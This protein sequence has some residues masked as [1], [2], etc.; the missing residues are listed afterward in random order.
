MKTR[1]N[2]ELEDYHNHNKFNIGLENKNINQQNIINNKF[3]F[4]DG[5][6][7]CS[8]LYKENNNVYIS[9]PDFETSQNPICSSNS[10]TNIIIKNRIPLN[11][12]I[13]GAVY[14]YKTLLDKNECKTSMLY[15]EDKVLVHRKH[16]KYL[17]DV[18]Y[19][20]SIVNHVNYELSY[21]Y[22]KNI[23]YD[24]LIKD[25]FKNKLRYYY[26][27]KKEDEKFNRL[28]TTIETRIYDETNK[29]ILNI[30]NTRKKQFILQNL[31][32]ITYENSNTNSLM[33]LL[34]TI[35]KKNSNTIL[36]CKNNVYS[37]HLARVEKILL[38]ITNIISKLTKF[39]KYREQAVDKYKTIFDKLYKLPDFS[40]IFLNPSDDSTFLQFKEV[41]QNIIEFRG[42][43]SEPSEDT[44]YGLKTLIFNILDDISVNIKELNNNIIALKSRIGNTVQENNGLIGKFLNTVEEYI[45]LEID[46]VKVNEEKPK[47]THLEILMSYKNKICTVMKSNVL[48]KYQSVVQ[49][50]SDYKISEIPD[51]FSL[52]DTLEDFKIN[53]D[54]IV[55]IYKN[56]DIFYTNLDTEYEDLP[57]YK[58]LY[59]IFFNKRN[60]Y[61]EYLQQPHKEFKDFI[62]PFITPEGEKKQLN[63]N[64]IFKV[65]PANDEQIQF[66]EKHKIKDLENIKESEKNQN[67][68]NIE[69]YCI[70]YSLDILNN[71]QLNYLTVK[72]KIIFSKNVLSN[73]CRTNILIEE[74]KKNIENY[75]KTI[76]FDMNSYKEQKKAKN[77]ENLPLNYRKGI[78]DFIYMNKMLFSITNKYIT[79]LTY[80]ISNNNYN[81]A[82]TSFNIFINS[83][84]GDE[85][86]L[87][88]DMDIINV[89]F[90]MKNCFFIK[91]KDY[92][93]VDDFIVIVYSLCISALA[94]NPQETLDA[95]FYT[96]DTN[97]DVKNLFDNVFHNKL[98]IYK[99]KNINIQEGSEAIEQNNLK[100]ISSIEEIVLS[101]HSLNKNNIQ[102]TQQKLN[103]LRSQLISELKKERFINIRKKLL[104]IQKF[105]GHTVT[106][107]INTIKLTTN[108][109]Q[110]SVI[111]KYFKNVE[112][113][114]I[115]NFNNNINNI[116]NLDN[117]YSIKNNTESNLY[118]IDLSKDLKYQCG[119]CDN[120]NRNPLLKLRAPNC[121]PNLP[122]NLDTYVDS[123]IQR[124]IGFNKD[125]Y[126]IMSFISEPNKELIYKNNSSIKYGRKGRMDSY[127]W[128]VNKGYK[129][130]TILDKTDTNEDETV[131]IKACLNNDEEN[132]PEK[133]SIV[134]ENLDKLAKN[135]N[136]FYLNNFYI[137][138]ILLEDLKNEEWVKFP[139]SHQ[140]YIQKPTKSNYYHVYFIENDIKYYMYLYIKKEK[141][142]YDIVFRENTSR[143]KEPFILNNAKWRFIRTEDYIDNIFDNVKIL[144][145]IRSKI[146]FNKSL[147]INNPNRPPP[148]KIRGLLAKNNTC[149]NYSTLLNDFFNNDEDLINNT[150]FKFEGY[151][152]NYKITSYVKSPNSIFNNIDGCL[153]LNY[154]TELKKL[155]QQQLKDG[156]IESQDDYDTKIATSKINTKI[157]LDPRTINA[158][159]EKKLV[160]YKIQNPDTQKYLYLDTT[161]NKVI[162]SDLYDD[163][164]KN[165]N[166]KISD[167][168]VLPDNFLWIVQNSKYNDIQINEAIKE[169]QAVYNNMINQSIININ[170]NITNKI[171]KQ[172]LK[173]SEN[174]KN[175]IENNEKFKNKHDKILNYVREMTKSD[176]IGKS[177]EEKEKIEK[178]FLKNKLL[179]MKGGEV[180]TMNPD[181]IENINTLVKQLKFIKYNDYKLLLN[182]LNIIKQNSKITLPSNF[183]FDNI[184]NRMRLKYMDSISNTNMTMYIY[185]TQMNKGSSK[186]ECNIKDILNFRSLEF[187][188]K[189]NDTENGDYNVFN[190][191]N[192][193]VEVD[194][195]TYD[196]NNTII[197]NITF[198]NRNNLI[199][200]KKGKNNILIKFNSVGNKDL[201]ISQI[202]INLPGVAE[203][204]I[205]NTKSDVL[206]YYNSKPIFNRGKWL[207]PI[208]NTNKNSTFDLLQNYG[209]SKRN[210]KIYD[211]SIRLQENDSK[212]NNINTNHITE[213]IT[214]FNNEIDSFYIKKNELEENALYNSKV[215]YI[216][217]NNQVIYIT[218]YNNKNLNEIYKAPCNYS[219][220]L[221][222]QGVT[223]TEIFS[224]ICKSLYTHIQIINK[225]NKSNNINQIFDYI[226]ILYKNN[227]YNKLNEVLNVS[228]RTSHTG[229]LLDILNNELRIEINMKKLNDSYDL[230]ELPKQNT[231][232]IPNKIT[233][234]FDRLINEP[235]SDG[236]YI[237]TNMKYT[238]FIHISNLFTILP[239][240][241][242]LKLDSFSEAHGKAYKTFFDKTSIIIKYILNIKNNTEEK[243]VGNIEDI[244]NAAQEIIDYYFMN[245]N[246]EDENVKNK[247]NNEI[248]LYLNTLLNSDINITN[249]V[250]DLILD[251]SHKIQN[252]Y[253]EYSE[254]I[255][256]LL[257]N[258][259]RFID[260]IYRPESF[261]DILYNM[262]NYFSDPINSEDPSFFSV[263][264][265]FYFKNEE[266][267]Y[268]NSIINKKQGTNITNKEFILSF[269]D[270][271][272]YY[273]HIEKNLPEK[274]IR[275]K[276]LNEPYIKLLKE[277]NNHVNNILRTVLNMKYANIKI[278]KKPNVSGTP[279]NSQNKFKNDL[280]EENTSNYINYDNID[281][282]RTDSLRTFNKG[283][284]ILFRFI[285]NTQTNNLFNTINLF[286]P[287]K[288]IDNTWK[289]FNELM[290]INYK[291][292][293]ITTLLNKNLNI[294]GIANYNEIFKSDLIDN[295]IPTKKLLLKQ[296]LPFKNDYSSVELKNICYI[297]LENKELYLYLNKYKYQVNIRKLIN[298]NLYLIYK[299]VYN[300]N[301]YLEYSK[302]DDIYNYEWKKEESH[303]LDKLVNKL[304][305]IDNT[306][307]NV[308]DT[309]EKTNITNEKMIEIEYVNRFSLIFSHINRF[310][311]NGDGDCNLLDTYFTLHNKTYR[312]IINNN[313]ILEILDIA[314]NNSANNFILKDKYGKISNKVGNYKYYFTNEE[315]NSYI[316]YSPSHNSDDML[317]L[318]N[319]FEFE[320]VANN[321]ISMDDLINNSIVNSNY[322]INLKYSLEENIFEEL[323]EN[324]IK[325]DKGKK[326]KIQDI[327]EIEQPADKNRYFIYIVDKET[328]L[329]KGIIDDY[330]NKENEN[331][332]DREKSCYIIPIKPINKLKILEKNE[333]G[334]YTDLNLSLKPISPNSD[335]FVIQNKNN[336]YLRAKT[337]I[338]Y[339]KPLRINLE[340]V[341]TNII[342]STYLFTIKNNIENIEKVNILKTNK[343]CLIGGQKIISTNLIK[344][345]YL[346]NINN[347]FNENSNYKDLCHNNTNVSFI[348]Y[349]TI[350]TQD[351]VSY[352]EC[353]EKCNTNETCSGFSMSSINGR[354]ICKTYEKKDDTSILFYDCNRTLTKT[355]DIGEIKKEIKI[356]T[357]NEDTGVNE[358]KTQ[359]VDYY[360]IDLINDG[361]YYIESKKK[362]SNKKNL[363][364]NLDKKFTTYKGKHNLKCTEIKDITK[365]T[366][367]SNNI[368]RLNINTDNIMNGNIKFYS[369]LSDHNFILGSY[370]NDLTN[371]EIR[372]DSIKNKFIWDGGENNKWYLEKTNDMYEYI[373]LEGSGEFKCPHYI[374]GYRTMEVYKNNTEISVKGP[375]EEIFTRFT[376]NE[377]ISI[378]KN[379]QNIN[380]LNILPPNIINYDGNIF[381]IANTTHSDYYNLFTIFENKK[382]YLYLGSDNIINFNNVNV[383]INNNEYLWK[384]NLYSNMMNE[385]RSF[386][387]L[388]G[389][390]LINQNILIREMPKD[391]DSG[392]TKKTNNNKNK[393]LMG[394]VALKNLING[395]SYYIKSKNNEY[396]CANK[397]YK[398]AE[399]ELNKIIGLSINSKLAT[400]PNKNTKYNNKFI[401]ASIDLSDTDYNIFKKYKIDD[402]IMWKL[403]IEEG[404]KP[405][406]KE[407][408]FYNIKHNKYLTFSSGV[409]SFIINKT[410]S[411]IFY[412]I[413]KKDANSNL[414]I[415]IN[416]QV[417]TIDKIYEL[418]LSD[419]LE[420]ND[421]AFINPTNYTNT[422]PYT[423]QTIFQKLE[424]G[425]IYRIINEG[426]KNNSETNTYLTLNNLNNELLIPYNEKT[427]TN[428]LEDDATLWRC[429]IN[430]DKT[431][432]FEL[433]KTGQKLGDSSTNLFKNIVNTLNF[434]SVDYTI[435]K[436]YLTDKFYIQHSTNE[437]Y[438]I[439]NSKNLNYNVCGFSNDNNSYDDYSVENIKYIHKIANNSEWV[440]TNKLYGEYTKTDIFSNELYYYLYPSKTNK[441]HYSFAYNY[442]S[443]YNV[444]YNENS[445]IETKEDKINQ[446]INTTNLDSFK[447]KNGFTLSTDVNCQVPSSGRKL[448]KNNISIVLDSYKYYYTIRFI[449]YSRK[450]TLIR[451]IEN[452]H[453]TVSID[454]PDARK[455]SIFNTVQNFDKLD[456]IQKNISGATTNQINMKIIAPDI[457]TDNVDNNIFYLSD[458]KLNLTYDNEFINIYINNK[459][460]TF[461]RK[462]NLVINQI[463]Y[464]S[465][466]TCEWT[467][468][469][470][471][472][473]NRLIN[474]PLWKTENIDNFI[475]NKPGIR[476]ISKIN[477]NVK[478]ECYVKK[479]SD[480]HFYIINDK[481]EYLSIT[482][483]SENQL[484]YE[485]QW[486]T[487]NSNDNCLWK[488]YDTNINIS[489]NINVIEGTPS[490]E[491]KLKHSFKCL[492]KSLITAA[493][494]E[495][496]N[497]LDDVNHSTNIMMR[498]KINNTTKLIDE[499]SNYTYSIIDINPDEDNLNYKKCYWTHNQNGHTS[500][501]YGSYDIGS[502]FTTD[503]WN[504]QFILGV[505]PSIGDKFL[506]K[507]KSN[508]GIIRIDKL[509]N[510]DYPEY[511]MV[512]TTAQAR[513]L[514]WTKIK[515][516]PMIKS[517]NNVY[518]EGPPINQDILPG[519]VCISKNTDSTS[520][521]LFSASCSNVLSTID[522]GNPPETMDGMENSVER[523]Y[524]ENK[525]CDE[526]MYKNYALVKAS[527]NPN[528]ILTGGGNKQTG[529]NMWITQDSLKPIP[530]AVIPKPT[531]KGRNETWYFYL[532]PQQENQNIFTNN[533]NVK[534]HPAINRPIENDVL[535]KQWDEDIKNWT[536][537]E[538][539]SSKN[540]IL[541]RILNEFKYDGYID[542]ELL[543]TDSTDK[544]KK[545]IIRG[546]ILPEN[547]VL[548]YVDENNKPI[549]KLSGYVKGDFKSYNCD[550]KN[551]HI[552]KQEEYMGKKYSN[553]FIQIRTKKGNIIEEKQKLDT[554]ENQ[555]NKCYDFITD[556]ICIPDGNKSKTAS[557]IIVSNGPDKVGTKHLTLNKN[558]FDNLSNL[559][560]LKIAD[561]QLATKH[562]FRIIN[563][564]GKY[565]CDIFINDSQFCEYHPSNKFKNI[566]SSEIIFQGQSNSVD[567]LKKKSHYIHNMSY[568]SLW[569]LEKNSSDNSYRIMNTYTGRFITKN[570][571]DSINVSDDIPYLYLEYAETKYFKQQISNIIKKQSSISYVNEDLFYIY[572]YEN[573]EKVYLSFQDV[574]IN[575]KY[576]NSAKYGFVK[577]NP[578]PFIIKKATRNL[579]QITD[580]SL[581]LPEFITNVCYNKTK[582][583]AKN[584][585]NIP[586]F[587][588][589][590]LQCLNISYL[591]R[592]NEN[593][594]YTD[595][596]QYNIFDLVNKNNDNF[597]SVPHNGYYELM[598]YFPNIKIKE[599]K[600]KFSGLF[601]PIKY[602]GEPS[603]NSEVYIINM[604]DW[605]TVGNRKSFDFSQIKNVSM[606]NEIKLDIDGKNY[607]TVENS[608]ISKEHIIKI[609]NTINENVIIKFK[610]YCEEGFTLN[611]V[612]SYGEPLGEATFKTEKKVVNNAIN[613]FKSINLNKSSITSTKNIEMNHIK[614]K[615]IK[616]LKKDKEENK[617]PNKNI[618]RIKNNN[619]I[620]D[621]VSS[622]NN[623]NFVLIFNP[624][625][626]AY[627]FY[628]N[629]NKYL[630]I[631]NISYFKL[632]KDDT[633]VNNNIKQYYIQSLYNPNL[634][635]N[636]N[637]SNNIIFGNLQQIFQITS[638]L[639]K[640][641]DKYMDISNIN[642]S[643]LNNIIYNLDDRIIYIQK[644]DSKQYLHLIDTTLRKDSSLPK[645]LLL[646]RSGI[647]EWKL[648]DLTKEEN[649]FEY[650]IKNLKNI[651]N[652]QNNLYSFINNEGNTETGC[653][654]N[655]YYDYNTLDIRTYKDV[656]NLLSHNDINKKLKFI[657][658]KYEE[659]LKRNKNYINRTSILDHI[660]LDD[661][662]KLGNSGKF[663]IY[664]NSQLLISNEVSGK[665]NL[666]IQIK[667]ND[668]LCKL[669]HIEEKKFVVYSTINTKFILSNKVTEYNNIDLLTDI[670]LT[671][672]NTEFSIFKYQG[673]GNRKTY[674]LAYYSKKVYLN[675]LDTTSEMY[676]DSILVQEYRGDFKNITN[677]D[678]NPT[679]NK[680]YCTICKSNNSIED[681]LI[682]GKTYTI[683]S[684]DGQNMFL[685]LDPYKI[686][687]SGP[688]KEGH[689]Y[690]IVQDLQ[691]DSTSYVKD[692]PIKNY[693]EKNI[694]KKLFKITD[695]NIYLT[696]AIVTIK[697]ANVIYNVIVW[698]TK[699]TDV[700]MI[701]RFEDKF[702][703]P[704][705][706]E[707][708][709]NIVYDAN[710]NKLEQIQNKS[711]IFTTY[712]NP[713]LGKYVKLKEL[714]FEYINKYKLSLFHIDNVDSQPQEELTDTE[715]STKSNTKRLISTCAWGEC[716]DLEKLPMTTAQTYLGRINELE[717]TYN[718]RQLG[719]KLDLNMIHFIKNI[720]AKNHN[721]I[722]IDSKYVNKDASYFTNIDLL[723][724]LFKKNDI[725]EFYKIFGKNGWTNSYNSIYSKKLFTIN[726]SNNEITDLDY[727][728]SFRNIYPVS[729][730][731]KKFALNVENIWKYN[732]WFDDS[733]HFRSLPNWKF[734]LVQAIETRVADDTLQI[735]L[736]GT[737]FKKMNLCNFMKNP[738]IIFIII[739][740]GIFIIK[741]FKLI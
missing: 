316:I 295:Y 480:N 400:D 356:P 639:S 166:Y 567:L 532:N 156:E 590:N 606:D 389:G 633:T 22:Y 685:S 255:N 327:S 275:K 570:K 155:Y 371:I 392:S 303:L 442:N 575:N 289:S 168:D 533:H 230:S 355:N 536:Y 311:N 48:Q 585:S 663:L 377:D 347:K 638:D 613:N 314:L 562:P 132:H 381:L 659:P 625:L 560:I 265:G 43:E 384:F 565:L 439:I 718:Y 4:K 644:K 402:D 161:T 52:L 475:E 704:G 25:K 258:D 150:K 75:I 390:Q 407:Y 154:N 106:S 98:Y 148:H 603:K 104:L 86:I 720:S 474:I 374:N 341:K 726:K 701:G 675:P 3:I 729:W 365:E 12:N 286:L 508:K 491:D 465:L 674:E 112:K 284:V 159:K 190:F 397:Y 9:E 509:V 171:Y 551:I 738:F 628:I 307:I 707:G 579:D 614:I 105:I 493:N 37:K 109:G 658:K 593:N 702:D 271:I 378:F 368:F 68:I 244:I 194:N 668:D 602:Y 157:K 655:L 525:T 632:I 610:I 16:E 323:D 288:K 558:L 198:Q 7:F 241:P 516:F 665:N 115:I 394:G 624:L 571:L 348:N 637:D 236:Q 450:S 306:G 266:G 228:T 277:F 609:Q 414:N 270:V 582:I 50:D 153:F 734:E 44:I 569:T 169:K 728:D 34:S 458:A 18:V 716:Q 713:P 224:Y 727:Y 53:K 447:N 88:D 580:E 262:I 406:D 223:D 403:I 486:T 134:T 217:N 126:R 391:S 6:Y 405:T 282:N 110:Y 737:T 572:Y 146:Y 652:S 203:L 234:V 57:A 600:F 611:Y 247:F 238:D 187:D 147:N 629:N 165:T 520:P 243:S 117:Y 425:K 337:L 741:Q 604:D 477:K 705:G 80:N 443:I 151:N 89:F 682:S 28:S 595:Y 294:Y 426:V 259:N 137:E 467:N 287:Y 479:H 59:D 436:K 396:I 583:C 264:H 412:N 376:L 125:T 206:V 487:D 461:F 292:K 438:N 60:T 693:K 174:N 220:I 32:N 367:Y 441:Y 445:R 138:N 386:Q 83:V 398:N 246:S 372:Y 2:A 460:I 334:K 261:V 185:F 417:K 160:Y 548:F 566:K 180:I 484:N 252:K 546:I 494:I 498:A 573:N 209:L 173:S 550:Y 576:T 101:K 131:I 507:Y 72:R 537:D 724:I 468:I 690:F 304:L 251:I 433:V 274:N 597:L 133:T 1:I 121:P 296:I 709:H 617:N 152:N 77:L 162:W 416:N 55:Q 710:D 535:A 413:V 360:T 349:N 706:Y 555:V 188:I 140:L 622:T 362:T 612:E 39:I 62:E 49:V 380:N 272:K 278:N 143:F 646:K 130:Y 90:N 293:N 717:N 660:Y 139:N 383:K 232:K 473:H 42:L 51:I 144:Y 733:P 99:T 677:I 415:I 431:Y 136:E 142:N 497:Y 15:E 74:Y 317:I 46:M 703:K 401:R 511:G 13:I 594:K 158:D 687:I 428:K 673:S 699:T 97:N 357:K 404:E 478:L 589:N 201:E 635:V 545:G 598:F 229:Y 592:K 20:N 21:V 71:F 70:K 490:E 556:R 435:D 183:G 735:K 544:T 128:E 645:P 549:D 113:I 182:Q 437:Y 388:K 93:T 218:I 219:S 192:I 519:N 242:F 56:I 172:E 36:D 178:K 58:T 661:V 618:I 457:Y 692:L 719:G 626:N 510:I 627:M 379:I 564:Y 455:N 429:I 100:I 24:T 197:N 102:Q 554:I 581:E 267:V 700:E 10:F 512:Y 421:W 373:V 123:H 540:I 453:N 280:V 670:D 653:Y 227:K 501:D 730:L 422:N 651:A 343:K 483:T 211:F 213:Y 528:N 656:K 297:K 615:Y 577:N 214:S 330:Y 619:P 8:Y 500:L 345:E 177:E 84:V 268:I 409:D 725:I 225:K 116:I 335:Y 542:Q 210:K 76:N 648:K 454:N 63:Y 657:K 456:Y 591:F 222:K 489:K 395:N 684:A 584:K 411:S 723:D 643:F 299:T 276:E 350:E 541:N 375:N 470:W 308:T 195:D 23:N 623:S 505:T 515:E 358:I 321:T 469:K 419:I 423:R 342:N 526:F 522:C 631:D 263:S 621:T 647:N 305:F 712:T 27:D 324:C 563:I 328:G 103:N 654:F 361:L 671:Q 119:P 309:A 114:N 329:D 260:C 488:L 78:E 366:I 82:V 240:I 588:N 226:T 163:N 233:L 122:Y 336:E 534:Y 552:I 45:K 353:R 26:F 620:I 499:I 248:K 698:K 506:V 221:E 73:I 124:D 61:K 430:K 204:I 524:F 722:K 313:N 683:N 145:N 300:I 634:Y 711:Y 193:S 557:N 517:Q 41:F 256:E 254:K 339:K 492:K 326:L 320:K 333:E 714:P 543:S 669:W 31:K 54:N 708:E 640:S 332:P 432:S 561:L 463:Y 67:I 732:N 681:N 451:I 440:I 393:E 325:R 523:L 387:I 630:T 531:Q 539:P 514:N 344:N 81:I 291:Y 547:Y 92:Q 689:N 149:D 79:D 208:K 298:S 568:E 574:L 666:F 694:L 650:T 418:Q 502:H 616:P 322:V 118:C 212:I 65:L 649:A 607:F 364:V 476:F 370:N 449:N 273:S 642:N 33:N 369:I 464:T 216:A 167:E 290:D 231:Q 513:W 363:Y 340:F 462:N 175:F 11:L 676:Y 94:K 667:L 636:V 691:I 164:S 253:N 359:S 495:S 679:T 91:D 686:K 695:D 312:K 87:I 281:F 448:G 530:P 352:F 688:S 19:F 715:K 269:A 245:S 318:N 427:F 641:G 170:E 485:T 482:G 346:T 186:Y 459:L 672:G 664:S 239:N 408:K 120:T 191:N 382:F 235:S 410:G 35:T 721:K 605:L 521:S 399:G 481:N 141:S 127:V 66:L 176:T 740:I 354:D 739:I 184:P 181:N 608:Q 14:F 385:A 587:E 444:I 680:D 518:I 731:E 338:Q 196:E 466:K 527:A 5:Y 237:Y 108:R 696:M 736:G 319:N 29:I 446:V 111:E 662:I 85:D 424:N 310:I 420:R 64:K 599:F 504:I 601:K 250:I 47:K 697:I 202:L 200:N 207:K 434:K 496:E 283:D 529:G 135:D 503:I 452:E 596:N 553:Y 351:D 678:K 315:C 538:T 30:N 285:R 279:T 559:N 331:V 578:T 189:S 40:Q 107:D 69:S 38:E 96:Y 129:N 205:N 301:Y 472:K 179:E 95:L 249:Y 471:W 17:I 257:K 302:T 199:N 215:F 586:L